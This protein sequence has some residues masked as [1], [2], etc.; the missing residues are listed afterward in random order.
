MLLDASNHQES[1]HED[2]LKF[3]ENDSTLAAMIRRKAA[4]VSMEPELFERAQKRSR[5]LGFPSFSAYMTQLLRADL[6]RR[7]ELN[8]MEEPTAPPP[9]TEARAE[10]H[11]PKPKKTKS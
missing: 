9:V 7:G 5:E 1:R 3:V 4:A 10:V 11:Y 2:V 6:I 8:I